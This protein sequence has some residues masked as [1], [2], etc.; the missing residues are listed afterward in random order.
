MG[1]FADTFSYSYVVNVC[2]IAMGISTVLIGTIPSYSQ[3]G[4]LAPIL[5]IIFR[6]IQGLSVGGQFPTLITLGVSDPKK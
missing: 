2:T 6:I 5:L 1:Y 3:I 4:I